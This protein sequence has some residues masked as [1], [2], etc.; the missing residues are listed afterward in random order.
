MVNKYKGT[1]V[2]CGSIV[3]AL[4]G[5]VF[6]QG[7]RWV[8][9][10]LCCE[11]QDHPGVSTTVFGDGTVLFRNKRGRCEDAPCCGCCNY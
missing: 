2:K 10:H 1:C 3:P 6:K 4:G 7:G 5:K 8:V 9:I 11:D